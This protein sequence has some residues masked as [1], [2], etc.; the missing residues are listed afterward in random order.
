MFVARTDSDV[1]EAGTALLKTKT[2]AF[3]SGFTSAN[4]E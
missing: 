4:F 3:T 1:T 2:N